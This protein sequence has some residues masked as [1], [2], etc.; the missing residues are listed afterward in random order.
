MDILIDYVAANAVTIIP[1]DLYKLIQ[2]FLIFF[3]SIPKPGLDL[4]W[5]NV[6]KD[7]Q[8]KII[9]LQTNLMNKFIEH[10]NTNTNV[11]D[12]KRTNTIVVKFCLMIYPHFQY[13]KAMNSRQNGPQM[14]LEF[15]KKLLEVLL[16]FFQNGL[17]RFE[18][19]DDHFIKLLHD[20][21]YHR[22]SSQSAPDILPI[23]KYV[24]YQ[25][26]IQ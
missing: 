10:P 8:I 13:H 16:L 2:A 23:L 17:A 1:E 26:N 4:F 9:D 21:F 3:Y 22:L 18:L 15:I 6:N 19:N 5:V 14:K 24:I 11:E 25:C 7:N 20:L 12:A